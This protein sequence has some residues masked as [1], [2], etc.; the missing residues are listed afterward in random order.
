MPSKGLIQGT[1]H[2]ADAL[3]LLPAGTRCQRFTSTTLMGYVIKLPCGTRIA[4]A[5][6][7]GQAW[8]DAAA[9][10]RANLRAPTSTAVQH[11]LRT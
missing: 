9:W 7:S 4:S 11:T 2:K 5:R 6:N 1:T 3:A 8:A 10:A